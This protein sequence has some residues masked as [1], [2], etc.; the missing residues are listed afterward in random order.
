MSLVLTILAIVIFLLAGFGAD[1]G[2]IDPVRLIA[3]GL[4][5]FAAAHIVFPEWGP[6]APRG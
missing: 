6:R 5:S 2:D 3:F 4:A 1:V